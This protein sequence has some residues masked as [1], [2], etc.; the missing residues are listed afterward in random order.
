MFAY[1][2]DVRTGDS[3]SI[4]SQETGERINYAQDVCIGD[5][6]WIAAHTILLKGSAIPDNSIVATGSVV[7]RP[8]ETR[9]IILGGN[10][11]KT[12]KDGITWS[13]QRIDRREAP[14]AVSPLR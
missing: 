2:I 6:V 13:R 7:T 11:A 8:F 12:I 4:I 3:H 5:H 9:G 10:P 14:D 1:D